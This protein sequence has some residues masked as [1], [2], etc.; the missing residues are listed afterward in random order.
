[1]FYITND[2][3]NSSSV[4]LD[5]RMWRGSTEGEDEKFEILQMRCS[6]GDGIHTISLHYSLKDPEAY[7]IEE[8]PVTSAFLIRILPGLRRLWK[9]HRKHGAV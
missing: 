8:Q 5:R 2:W 3:R 4:C 9:T 6:A 7:G 1:M